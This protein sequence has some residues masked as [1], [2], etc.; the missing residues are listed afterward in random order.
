MP[1]PTA[2]DVPAQIRAESRVGQRFCSIVKPC[3][4]RHATQIVSPEARNRPKPPISRAA[5]R[6]LCGSVMHDFT[7]WSALAGGALIGLAASLL[8]LVSG[9]IAGISGM[10]GGLLV[11]TRGDVSWRALFLA[12]L[13]LAGMLVFLVAPQSFG[14]SPRGLVVL[15]LAGIFVGIGTRIG[16]GCTSGHGVCG[17]SRLSVRSLIATLTFIATGVGTVTLLRLLGGGS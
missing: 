15:M 7:P 1:R 4:E 12:G 14:A 8:L 10:L 3:F 9:R 16:N 17:L 5:R 6:V 2:T 13:V 11:P